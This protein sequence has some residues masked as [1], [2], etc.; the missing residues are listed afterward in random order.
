MQST[1]TPAGDGCTLYFDGVWRHCCDM[2]DLAYSLGTVD[3]LAADWELFQCVAA[4]GNI[5]HAIVMLAG[6]T[7]AGWI[8]W[9][10]A[11]WRK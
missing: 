10:K 8:W 5:W 2:H 6:V 9:L 1:S 3:K 4:T 11:R 7:L